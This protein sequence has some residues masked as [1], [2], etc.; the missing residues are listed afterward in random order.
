[1]K[2]RTSCAS[3]SYSYRDRTGGRSCDDRLRGMVRRVAPRLA[4]VRVN[5]SLN[6]ARPGFQEHRFVGSD[7]LRPHEAASARGRVHLDPAQLGRTA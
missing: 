1:M 2:E 6:L 7:T 4:S 5:C 3:E